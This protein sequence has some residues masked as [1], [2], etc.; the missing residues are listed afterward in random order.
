MR[1]IR[2][3]ILKEFAEMLRNPTLIASSLI[4][5]LIF[6]VLPMML[7][8]RGASGEG[9]SGQL[10]LSQAGELVIRVSPELRNLPAPTLGQIFSFRQNAVL[11]LF[12]PI[13]TS[14]TI[15][16]HSIIGEKQTRSLEPLLAAPVSSLQVLLAKSLSGAIPA[17]GLTWIIFGV[18][19]LEMEFL[20]RPQVLPNVL[21]P[22]TWLL[23]FV[24]CPLIAVMG[25]IIGVIVSSRANDP[26]TAQQIAGILVLPVIGL[27]IAQ[28]QGL[29]F[30]T[31][32]KVLVTVVVL[33]VIDI[34]VLK[35]G[36]ALFDR[37]TILLRWK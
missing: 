33:A 7:G 19:A 3:I 20:A 6:A 2:A 36:V 13:T 18:Y 22:T 9:R 10:S 32:P 37:E 14:L 27:F 1:V 4:P 25:L 34:V 15:A 31:L 28:I 29:Y 24:I 26:R 16:A 5:A 21:I 8:L 23:I 17:L 11:L 35:V 30:L 12:I